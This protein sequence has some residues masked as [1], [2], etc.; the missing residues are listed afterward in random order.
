MMNAELTKSVNAFWELL[1]CALW[2]TSPNIS[3]FEELTSGEWGDI[4][5]L[6]KKHAVIGITFPILEKAFVCT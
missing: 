5:Q 2:N 3:L 4:Y 6:V 1:R